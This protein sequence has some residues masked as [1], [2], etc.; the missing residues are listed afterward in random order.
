MNS[1]YV[2]L[3]IVLSFETGCAIFVFARKA[4]LFATFKRNVPALITKTIN[5][6]NE[7]KEVM[8][9]DSVICT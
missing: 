4:R 5:S 3:E 9:K 7:E 2:T 6:I 1:I 8:G